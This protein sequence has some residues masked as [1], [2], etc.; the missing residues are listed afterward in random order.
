MPHTVP[1]RRHWRRH[2]SDG[3]AGSA[4]RPGVIQNLAKPIHVPHSTLLVVLAFVALAS[5]PSLAANPQ[6]RRVTPP[7]VQRGTEVEVQ[8]EGARLDD[9]QGLL[10]YHPGIEVKRFEVKNGRPKARL[11]VAAQCR[12]GPHPVRLRTTSGISNLVTFNVGPFAQVD[13]TE[14]NS[15]FDKPQKI[16]LNTTVTGVIE[17]EDVDYFLIEAKK[18]ERLAVEIEGFR[19]GETTFD[20]FVAIL[21]PKRFVLA[22]D[23]DT[24]LTWQDVA[25]SILVPEDGT[26]SIQ[27]RESSFGGSGQCRYRLHV[28]SFPRPQAVYPAGGK[29]GQA[30]EVRWMGDAKGQWSEKLT[31]PPAPQPMFGLLAH[32]DQGIAPSTNPFRL[33]RLQNVLETEPNNRPAEANSFE[34]PMALNGVIG[35]PE[36]VDRFKFKVKKGQ[37]CDVRVFARSLRSPLDSVLSIQRANGTGVGAND[38]GTT[39]DSYLRFTA[40]DD[41]EYLI[42]IQDHLK[43]GGPNYV[44]RIEVAP[45]EPRLLLSLPE[46]TAFID[47]TAPVP[48]GNRLAVMV[49]AQR[50]DCSGEVTL[51]LKNLPQGVKAEP[52]PIAEGRT[53]VPILLTATAEAPLAGSL[54]DVVGRTTEGERVVEGRLEQ[55]TSMVRGQNNREVWNHYT[56]RMAVAVTQRAPFWIELIQPK[57]PIVQ[58]GSMGLKVVAKREGEF[59]APITLRMLSNPPGLSAPDSVSIPE[60]KT[61]AIIPLTADTRAAAGTWPIAVIGE[62]AVGDGPVRVSSQVVKLDVSE[63]YLKFTFPMIAVDQGQ[64]TTLVVK[65]EITKHFEGEASV[66]LVGLPNEVTSQPQ[67]ITKDSKE[68]SIPISTTAKSPP[69][70]HKGLL[71]KVVITASGEPIP[72]LLGPGEL[73]IQPPLPKKSEVA[74]APPKQEPAKPAAKE[75]PLSRLEQ[76]RQERQKK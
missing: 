41:G 42:T 73:R 16:N 18:G 66:E 12:L 50:E 54:V 63:P 61:E 37:V 70:L 30:T 65:I 7:G 67:R 52:L 20:P 64:P 13:E 4:C 68:L 11:A 27:V 29:L 74:A 3:L 19:L 39:P 14:P 17:N 47:V 28:G 38:D 45:V 60:G 69:G 31:L 49:N 57:V 21:D 46:Q 24:P 33:S 51:E 25:L 22:S 5:A 15:E 35:E 62:A 43:Q 2:P 56:D 26:Y 44:Y 76:L 36:D 23:D 59:K 1:N 53:M 72:H 9:A 55:R 6:L 40:P 48:Q 32:D 58:N 10:L 8:F 75:K 34:V 71:C